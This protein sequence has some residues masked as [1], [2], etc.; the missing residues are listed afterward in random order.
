MR[1]IA[2]VARTALVA[3][4]LTL[5][6]AVAT[7]AGGPVGI[8]DAH[9]PHAGSAVDNRAAFH[10]AMRKLWEDHVTWT[11]LFIVSAATDPNAT[12]PDLDPTV[13]R[14]LQNQ[15]DIGDAVKPFYGDAAGD[16]LTVLLREHILLAADIVGDA[17]AGNTSAQQQAVDEWYANANE[18]ADFLHDANPRN[19]A[20]AD[21]R[22]MMKSHLD[23]TLDEAVARLQG[24]Y[25]DDVVAYDRVHAEILEMAD[26][27]SEGIVAQFPEK[28]GR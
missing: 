4:G 28:F 25:A 11:R 16:H 14:L 20:D 15:V 21:M 8:A 17:K 9:A 19:W 24:R 22:A 7:Q 27:L 13:A 5:A 1:P 6:V 10:D 2:R 12:L 26:M 18:I 3:A 23:L